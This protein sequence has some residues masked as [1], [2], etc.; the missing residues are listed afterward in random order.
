V[1]DL[2]E[3]SCT[4]LVTEGE[5]VGIVI[6]ISL[7]GARSSI[8]KLSVSSRLWDQPC[9]TISHLLLPYLS[10]AQAESCFKPSIILV[11]VEVQNLFV[12]TRERSGRLARSVRTGF[13]HSD[14]NQVRTEQVVTAQDQYRRSPRPTLSLTVTPWVE[15]HHRPR[16]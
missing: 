7:N 9:H 16:E 4:L 11:P 6:W 3:P 15:Y 14:Q 12:R 13:H 10:F 2:D 8:L 5:S 1:Y